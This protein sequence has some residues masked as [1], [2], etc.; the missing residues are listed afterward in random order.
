MVVVIHADSALEPLSLVNMD[1]V[2][3]VSKLYSAPSSTFK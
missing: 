3:D 2:A 1:C